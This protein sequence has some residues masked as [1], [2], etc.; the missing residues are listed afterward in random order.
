[1]DRGEGGGEKKK[2]FFFFLSY[3][4]KRKGEGEKNLVR[5]KEKKGENSGV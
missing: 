5:S 2:G 1:M 4:K 3:G